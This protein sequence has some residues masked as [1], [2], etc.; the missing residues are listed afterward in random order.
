MKKAL[1]ITFQIMI[2]FIGATYANDSVTA[3][4]KDAVTG[5]PIESAYVEYDYEY[6]LSNADGLFD[7][8]LKNKVSYIKISHISYGD[9]II[10]DLTSVNGPILLTQRPYQLSETVY[11]PKDNM[12]KNLRALRK[13]YLKYGDGD[14]KNWYY[15]QLTFRNDSCI[16]YIE[17]L[18]TGKG[19][20]AIPELKLQEGRYGQSKTGSQNLRLTFY[21]LFSFCCV[22]PVSALYSNFERVYDISIDKIIGADFEDE[23]VVYR[24]TPLKNQSLNIL[25]Y[26]KTNGNILMRY[27]R[28]LRDWSQS[29]ITIPNSK[30]ANDAF[31]IIISYGET[32]LNIPTIR[33]I[34]MRVDMDVLSNSGSA[35]HFF[36]NALL[37]K[38]SL[39]SRNKRKNIKWDDDLLSVIYNQNYKSEFWDNNPIVKRTSQEDSILKHF[40]NNNYFILK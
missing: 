10:S 9:T 28:V 5:L 31:K 4:L 7:I 22:E 37:I 38:T 1:L 24:L 32:D 3:S 15:R 25:L 27:E 21:D 6:T 19:T 8:P 17:A 26:V 36:T 16:E 33:S 30:I 12:I 20:Y 18:F 29:S 2:L 11:I 39:K 35:C 23:V 14:L 13:K 34:S 40:K